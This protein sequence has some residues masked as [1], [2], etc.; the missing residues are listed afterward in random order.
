MTL[1]DFKTVICFDYICIYLDFLTYKKV[2]TSIVLIP[3]R[4]STERWK[5]EEYFPLL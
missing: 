1:N 4:I 3:G 2:M 5:V